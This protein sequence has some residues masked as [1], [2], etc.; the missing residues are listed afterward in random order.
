MCLF[1]RYNWKKIYWVFK[2]TFTEV[3]FL[4]YYGNPGGAIIKA[5]GIAGKT[6]IAQALVKNGGKKIIYVGAG[7]QE[8]STVFINLR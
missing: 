5:L 2:K 7:L 3:T 4:K 6:E 8:L 1:S